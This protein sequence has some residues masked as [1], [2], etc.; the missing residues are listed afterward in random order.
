[1]YRNV[2]VPVDGSPFSREAVL[3]GL[4]IASQSGATLRLVRVGSSSSMMHGGPDGFTIENQRLSELHSNELADLYAIAAECRAHT[5]VNVTASLQYGPVVDALIGYARRQRVDLI[6]MRSHTRRGLA[7]VWFGSVADGLIRESGIPVLVVKPPS[8]AT[9]LDGGFRYKKI[10]VPLDGSPLA[11]QA[12]QPAVRLARIEGAS[13]T[14]VR[15]VAPSTGTDGAVQSSLGPARAQDVSEARDYLDSLLNASVDHSMPVIR[16][17][18]ISDDI[19]GAILQAAEGVEADIIAI[20][21]HGR[22]ALARA[23]SGSV[24]DRLMREA[25]ISTMILRPGIQ[26]AEPIAIKPKFQTAAI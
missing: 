9:A 7:R 16:R 17:V 2:M 19:P 18:I 20:A 10:I 26:V 1:M 5:T 24:A 3:Q 11:E 22:S 25:P 4:R 21:T 14:L 6:V 15:V 23:R 8:V 13:V 12:L